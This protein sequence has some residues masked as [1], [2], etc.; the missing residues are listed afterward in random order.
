VIPVYYNV[1]SL[2]A[3]RAS[4]LATV[5]GLG[6]VTFVFASVFML[7]HGIEAALSSG[8]RT[9]NAVVLRQGATAEVVSTVDRDT[10]RALST[11]PEIA[12]G[13]DGRP[14]VVGEYVV[15]V[16][17][18]RAG[19][20]FVNATA[21][22]VEEGSYAARPSVHIV[23][24]RAPTPGTT[25]IALGSALVGVSPGA[26]VGGELSF[27]GLRWPVV[28]RLGASGAAYESELWAD[29][30]RLGRAFDRF[31]FSSALVHLRSPASF[32][33]FVRAVES[34]SRFTVKVLREDTYWADQA[35]GMTTFIRVLGLFVA[36]VFS[37]GAILGAMITMYA[38]VAARTRELAMMRAV[39]F[40]RGSVL[41]SVVVESALLGAAGGAVGVVAAFFM[42]FVQI[43]TLN[44]QTFSDLRFGFAPTPGILLGAFAFALGMGL[45]GGLLPAL[46][47]ARLPIVEATR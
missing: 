16:A 46:R 35:S 23:E 33:P 12:T 13:P 39:G 47:A 37:A 21:R 14:L 30:D 28:G 9:D 26:F 44:F 36:F 6:L 34:D 4:T 20:N 8:G 31:A 38:Q 22:G 32:A 15:L 1:R 7:S 41:A 40:S 45:V 42:R 25:E 18:P 29:A 3:R 10:V 19:G 27:A 17:L 43:R 24:G 5:T 2:A 11:L